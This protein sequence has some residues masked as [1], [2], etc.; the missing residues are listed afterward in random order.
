MESNDPARLERLC[1]NLEQLSGVE[2]MKAELA[3]RADHPV[4]SAL[5]DELALIMKRAHCLMGT[6]ECL[7]AP[8]PSPQVRAILAPDLKALLLDDNLQE[9]MAEL[10]YSSMIWGAPPWVEK[11]RANVQNRAR[12]T[13]ASVVA[14]IVREAAERGSGNG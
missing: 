5:K 2:A 7:A 8:Q 1:S 13:A 14:F 6:I 4:T 9:E 10:I 12:N 11:G 3:R